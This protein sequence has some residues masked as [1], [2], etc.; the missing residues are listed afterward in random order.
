VTLYEAAG[1][2]R[3]HGRAL[4]RLRAA[5]G[6]VHRARQA[7]SDDWSG[8]TASEREVAKLVAAGL[9]NPEIAERLF[10]SRRTVESHLRRTFTKLGFASRV[11]LAVWASEPERRA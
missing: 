9:N 11:E 2:R 6:R 8:L 3:D 5:G 1:A 10:I 4:N 7:T